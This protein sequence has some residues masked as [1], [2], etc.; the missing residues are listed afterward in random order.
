MTAQEVNNYFSK[1][2]SEYIRETNK[3]IIEK[4]K[5]KEK[6]MG[7]KLNYIISGQL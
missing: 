1:L 3:K 6:D 5:K 2:F 7:G 4:V